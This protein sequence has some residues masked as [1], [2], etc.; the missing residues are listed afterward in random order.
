MKKYILSIFLIASIGGFFAETA[1]A[2]TLRFGLKAGAGFF[3][4]HFS[5][6]NST[7]D[8]GTVNFARIWY[9]RKNTFR[10]TLVVGGIAEYDFTEKFMLS[11]GLNLTPKYTK[12]RV[13]DEQFFKT[14]FN[15]NLLYL[16][17]PATVYYT[18]RQFFLGVGGYLG[19]TIAGK[20]KNT[21]TTI[22]DSTGEEE[23]TSEKIKVTFGDDQNSANFRRFD[24][25][26][27]AEAGFGLKTVRL[28]LAYDF[29]LANNLPAG[30]NANGA[31][32][33]GSLRHQAI[34]AMLT[35]FWGTKK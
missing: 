6:P 31:P 27:R 20:W 18:H 16:Q 35:Y 17:V 28:T 34:Y 8:S 13:I 10:P 19:L 30:T 11:A 1:S 3:N 7:L 2:Q 4:L 9:E 15:L 29:G 12:V 22:N 32:F 5:E 21:F 33:D 23:V 24:Y 26:A 14:D 25:G